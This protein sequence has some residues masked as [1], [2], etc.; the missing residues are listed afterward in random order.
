MLTWGV[1]GVL[2]R[3]SPTGLGPKE[4][5]LLGAV[6]VGHSGV[7]RLPRVALCVAVSLGPRDAF[8]LASPGVV[9][10]GVTDVVVDKGV[11]LLGIRVHL[12]LTVTSL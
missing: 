5:P 10:G 11:G 8:L 2:G 1:R 6:A 4:A 7:V 12:V 3:W 9:I